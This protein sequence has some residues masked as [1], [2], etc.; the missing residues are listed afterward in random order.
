[1][2]TFPEEIVGIS[3][4]FDGSSKDA[5][6]FPLAAVSIGVRYFE[7]HGGIKILSG[8]VETGFRHVKPEEYK[9]F[10][11][12]IRNDYLP[13]IYENSFYYDCKKDCNLNYYLKRS[14]SD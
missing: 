5:H 7:K 8:G 14:T 9:K 12:K 10:A 1:L 2:R 11:T 13:N 6:L 4:H 3:D